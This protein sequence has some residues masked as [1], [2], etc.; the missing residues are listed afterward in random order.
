MLLELGSIDLDNPSA[1]YIYAKDFEAKDQVKDAMGI[2][3]FGE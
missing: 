3:Y 2:N 1:I